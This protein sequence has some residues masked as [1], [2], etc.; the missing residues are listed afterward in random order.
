MS[1]QGAT[2]WDYRVR[3]MEIT[4]ELAQKI[5]IENVNQSQEDRTST[6]EQ[7]LKD[8]WRIVDEVLP[9]GTSVS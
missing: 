4:W 1:E 3:R 7:A 9:S 6:Y 5:A 8:A 2:R